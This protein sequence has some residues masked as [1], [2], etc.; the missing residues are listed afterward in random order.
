MKIIYFKNEIH[1]YFQSKFG[2]TRTR[3]HV[4]TSTPICTHT[5]HDGLSHLKVIY[6]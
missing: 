6:I 5:K 4:C 3:A 1:K 2:D